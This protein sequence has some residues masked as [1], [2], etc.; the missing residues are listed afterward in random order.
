MQHE[1]TEQRKSQYVQWGS[2]DSFLRFWICGLV[3][4]GSSANPRKIA[5]KSTKMKTKSSK[6]RRKIETN[7]IAICCQVRFDRDNLVCSHRHDFYIFCKLANELTFFDFFAV[8]KVTNKLHNNFSNNTIYT[9]KCMPER[10]PHW[11]RRPAAGARTARRRPRV[12][13]PANAS[14]NVQTVTYLKTAP[15]QKKCTAKR[16]IYLCLCVF[17]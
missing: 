7:K 9:P 13:A 12:L 17:L 14:L 4:G 1:A 8:F 6:K 11:V 5:R 16:C 2:R 10:G 3:A 15:N